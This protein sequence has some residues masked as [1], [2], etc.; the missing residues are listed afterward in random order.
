[1]LPALALSEL[2]TPNVQGESHHCAIVF[3]HYLIILAIGFTGQLSATM[4]NRKTKPNSSLGWLS[5]EE[6]KLA[7]KDLCVYTGLGVYVYVQSP[8]LI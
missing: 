2:N 8:A 6:R 1:M 4:E 5:G 7:T 3:Y